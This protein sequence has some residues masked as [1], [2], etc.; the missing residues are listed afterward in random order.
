L[1]TFRW[2]WLASAS[3]TTSVHLIDGQGVPL[4]LTFARGCWP[5]PFGWPAPVLLIVGERDPLVLELNREAQLV[6]GASC[7]LAVV[8]AA[9]HLFEEPGALEEVSL[10]AGDW[11]NRHLVGATAQRVTSP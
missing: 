8:A 1:T 11:F 3:R 9:T 10:P 2:R 7:A 5:T 4:W 6:L